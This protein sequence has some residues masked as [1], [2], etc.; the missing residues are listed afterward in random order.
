MHQR[1]HHR[2][3]IELHVGRII[4]IALQRHELAVEI[5][6]FFRKC[7]PRLDRAHRRPAMIEFEHEILLPTLSP[8]MKYRARRRP[9]PPSAI[10]RRSDTLS[11]NSDQ[12]L[13]WSLLSYAGI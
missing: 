5:Y 8:L 7:Q 9:S 11:V 3:G 2:I 10:G 13:E 1:R 6:A 12:C 4:L